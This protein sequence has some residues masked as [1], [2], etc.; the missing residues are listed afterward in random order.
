MNLL[1]QLRDKLFQTNGVLPSSKSTSWDFCEEE[2]NSHTVGGQQKGESNHL[3]WVSKHFLGFL[4]KFK[5]HN[6]I[7]SP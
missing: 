4:K 3:T 5:E 1:D 7:W 6:T 2:Q